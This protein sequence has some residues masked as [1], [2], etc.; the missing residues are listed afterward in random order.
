[1]PQEAIE[2]FG[3]LPGSQYATGWVLSCIG[4][5]YFEMVD[6]HHAALA[7]EWARKADPS[8]LEVT[9]AP[10]HIADSHTIVC[11]I[12]KRDTPTLQCCP[13]ASR[14]SEGGCAKLAGA[15][16]RKLRLCVSM[17]DREVG[18]TGVQ[19]NKGV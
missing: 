12:G 15:S 6:Y 17:S 4:R 16:A 14:G 8:R 10:L 3:R 19:S 11:P 1:M 2:T 18:C 5:A 9:P 13:L 7:F